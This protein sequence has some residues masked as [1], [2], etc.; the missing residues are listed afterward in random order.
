MCTQRPD[1]Q[2]CFPYLSTP[3]CTGKKIKSKKK[4]KKSASLSARAHGFF[5]R[6]TNWQYQRHFSIPV[7]RSLLRN[8]N[9]KQANLSQLSR[10]SSNWWNCDLPTD[11]PFLCHRLLSTAWYAW[12]MV[13][14]LSILSTFSCRAFS[15]CTTHPF[16]LAVP[17]FENNHLYQ[18]KSSCGGLQLS[19]AIPLV[20]CRHEASA[21]PDFPAS[22]SLLAV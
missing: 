5:N 1:V 17:S 9:F 21:P 12:L 22:P 3:L 14:T 10:Q 15:I 11:G 18:D 8:Q 20:L 6:K 16:V 19:L 2:H 13:A 4:K 7:K